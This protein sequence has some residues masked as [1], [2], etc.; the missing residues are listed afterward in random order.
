MN[1]TTLDYPTIMIITIMCNIALYILLHLT[2][3]TTNN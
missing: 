2:T 3:K 1:P